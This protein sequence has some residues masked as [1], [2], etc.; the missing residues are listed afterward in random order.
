MIGDVNKTKERRHSH[1]TDQFIHIQEPYVEYDGSPRHTHPCIPHAIWPSLTLASAARKGWEFSTNE[2]T[3]LKKC[4]VIF[5]LRSHELRKRELPLRHVKKPSHLE[6][7]SINEVGVYCSSKY[8]KITAFAVSRN[9][10]SP[11]AHKAFK[12]RC[13]STAQIQHWRCEIID[14]KRLNNCDEYPAE[15]HSKGQ[16]F[17]VGTRLVNFRVFNHV[18]SW[19]ITVKNSHKYDRYA[20]SDEVKYSNHPRIKDGST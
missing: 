16:K 13:N 11:I 3:C 7:N 19:K 5:C 20:S 12:C 6:C 2:R 1:S 17:V 8:L 4:L 9:I 10:P 14:G 15:C 18:I